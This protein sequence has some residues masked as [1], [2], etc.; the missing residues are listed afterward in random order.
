MVAEHYLRF[1]K[2]EHGLDYTALRYGNVYGP[3]Q[4]PAGEAGVIAIFIGKFLAK[5]GVRIDWDGDQTRD[6]VYV[7]DIAQANVAALER[8]GG[9]CYVIGT[10]V[11]TSVN[12]VYRALAE[13]TGYEPNIDFAPK[14]S[15]DV[16]DA[17][18]NPVRANTELL[19]KAQIPL[20]EG[21]RRTVEYFREREKTTV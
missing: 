12:D 18:F 3:R 10:G 6:Y 15:G 17:Q 1:F 11:R 2:A 16:R 9:E 8:G 7:G 21:M 13:V 20:V 4:D 19:W 5:Q 14:R